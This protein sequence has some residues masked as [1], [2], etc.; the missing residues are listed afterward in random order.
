M[1]NL[2]SNN[3]L[4]VNHRPSKG[5]VRYIPPRNKD[6]FPRPIWLEDHNLPE[7]IR[8]AYSI[9]S[10]RPTSARRSKVAIIICF[11][12]PEDQLNSDLRVWCDEFDIPPVKVKVYNDNIMQYNQLWY[13][14]ALLDVCAVITMNPYAE[15]AVFSARNA[16]GDL[17]VP[18]KKAVDEGFNI[19]SVSLGYP[20]RSVGKQDAF[21]KNNPDVCIFSAAGNRNVPTYLSTMN[22][23]FACGATTLF[24]S[25]DNEIE[26]TVAPW[27]ASGPSSFGEIPNYQRR[28]PL[29]VNTMK[30]Q[31]KCVPDFSV[32]GSRFP[33]Y[34]STFS[35]NDGDIIGWTLVDGT[36]L[37]TPFLAGIFSIIDQ[38][39]LNANM[40]ILR[41]SEIYD[42]LSRKDVG[43]FFIDQTTGF[44]YRDMLDISAGIP[45]YKAEEGFDAVS[46]YGT[47]K[48]KKWLDYFKN[49]KKY[50]TEKLDIVQLPNVL[51]PAK[52]AQYYKI[53]SVPPRES[54]RKTRVGI[55]TVFISNNDRIT[56]VRE[57]LKL[58]CDEYKST[59]NYANISV[60]FESMGVSSTVFS[61]YTEHYNQLTCSMQ[62]ILSINPYADI[63]VVSAR[64]LSVQSM[65]LAIERACTLGCE[66]VKIN[67][68]NADSNSFLESTKQRG[69]EPV[70]TKYPNVLFVTEVG[71]SLCYPS[72]SGRVLSVSST[73]VNINDAGKILSEQSTLLQG[74]GESSDLTAMPPYQ[75]RISQLSNFKF[76]CVPDVSA[77]GDNLFVTYSMSQLKYQRGAKVSA[78][79]VVGMFS[80]LN[81]RRINNNLPAITLGNLHTIFRRSDVSNFFYDISAGK[82]LDQRNQKLYTA[83]KG[84]DVCTGFGVPKISQFINNFGN[85]SFQV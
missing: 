68:L 67:Y 10:L 75:R 23:V 20:E 52:L 19:L 73:T 58:Y 46:G 64:D 70:F 55:I 47:P 39:K 12:V 25:D 22:G 78:S 76:R 30:L 71:I 33:V 11:T 44:S 9:P 60:N 7:K 83:Q 82:S 56:R 43:D 57:D 31:T 42:V 61:V 50:P 32:N 54:A 18:L 8:Y 53:P 6:E 21:V 74:V 14:E 29:L 51:T 79:I 38:Y 72:T 17:N 27:S 34:S 65:A 15:I 84:F 81:Q 26:E 77:P 62:T 16:V 2:S 13:K 35:V 24:V 1:S 48:L 59:I 69:L 28:I 5:K 40:G 45:R 63:Y 80:L 37:S 66:I 4:S 36:S 3:N 41:R 49:M 85:F